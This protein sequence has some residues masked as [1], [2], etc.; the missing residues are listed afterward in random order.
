MPIARWPAI[1]H[2]PSTD[3]PTT[4]ASSVADS[5]GS[6]RPV[7]EP[8]ARSRSWTFVSSSFN[9]EEKTVS[10]GDARAVARAELIHPAAPYTGVVPPRGVAADAL[11]PP[12]R[13]RVGGHGER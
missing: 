10:A 9:G 12:P 13:R 2:Q 3:A 11:R 7:P 6:T 1:V 5:P 8:F 4:P